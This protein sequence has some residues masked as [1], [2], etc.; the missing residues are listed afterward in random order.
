MCLFLYI[1]FFF[2]INYTFIKLFNLIIPRKM[3][4]FNLFIF[5]LF[6]LCKQEQNKGNVPY[7]QWTTCENGGYFTG[8]KCKETRDCLINQSNKPQICLNGECCTTEQFG[9]VGGGRINPTKID[10][11]LDRCLR[12]GGRRLREIIGE[13]S[14]HS[15]CN[16]LV[17]RIPELLSIGDNQQIL[18]QQK[19]CCL[20]PRILPI[21]FNDWAQA[22]PQ[23]GG[24]FIGLFCEMDHRDCQT[25]ADLT[26]RLPQRAI[27]ELRRYCCIPRNRQIERQR[28]QNGCDLGDFP[29]GSR[30]DP[31][32]PRC[33][34]G[35]YC[36]SQNICC[37]KRNSDYSRHPQNPY[38]SDDYNEQ[39]YSIN[40]RRAPAY[41]YDEQPSIVTCL[42]GDD[43][44]TLTQTCIN[45]LCCSTSGD[46]WKYA[47]GGAMAVASCSEDRTCLDRLVCTSSDYCCECLYGQAAGRCI[48][49]CPFNYSC[50]S[51]GEYCCPNCPRGDRPYGSCFNGKCATGYICS[52]GNI[53]CKRD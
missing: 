3:N 31:L 13:C 39:E 30:C 8:N 45:G 18:C 48:H 10:T 9:N 26:S 4:L 38:R 46:E 49:G 28:R 43:C 33:F 27:C 32:R 2:L 42:T 50:D 35:E 14:K 15:D 41:C 40:G 29:T 44:K 19:R 7:L 5:T 23:S 51:R 21:G 47:C 6:N 16:L 24:R 12:N 11:S 20:M 22:C 37:L 36:G 25:M 53:C 52:A 17:G 1:L 34:P